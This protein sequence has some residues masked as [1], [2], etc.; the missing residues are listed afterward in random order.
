YIHSGDFEK[1][2][3]HIKT[4]LL[5]SRDTWVIARAQLLATFLEALQGSTEALQ[6]LEARA[7][8]SAY[9]EE[10]PSILFMLFGLTGNTAYTSRLQKDFPSSIE[11]I[12]LLKPMP[13]F[14]FGA[15]VA[16]RRATTEIQEGSSVTMQDQKR[17]S[18]GAGAGSV[19][20]QIGLFRQE[21]NAR[22]MV[23]RLAVKGFVAN[24]GTRTIQGASY[25]VV[26]VDGGMDYNR[27]IMQLKDAGFESFPL[28]SK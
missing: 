4:I 9:R 15:E 13:L 12:A 7:A 8:D 6:L 11:S 14:F 20:L 24:L 23:Q 27:T 5:T 1:A 16:A 10:Q 19:P 18:P 17:E 28:L 26:T 2:A 3:S 21:E 22:A 25:W